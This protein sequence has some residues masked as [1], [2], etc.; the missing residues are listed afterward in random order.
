MTLPSRNGCAML[1]KTKVPN[2]IGKWK[3]A[4]AGAF[5]GTGVAIV[6]DLITK[7]SNNAK[8]K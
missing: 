4:L 6:Y 7:Y 5:I 2:I 3:N 1:M 8:N